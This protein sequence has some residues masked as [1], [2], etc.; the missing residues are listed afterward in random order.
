M[1]TDRKGHIVN[2]TENGPDYIVRMARESNLM[3][4]HG[5]MAW[6]SISMLVTAADLQHAK[7]SGMIRTEI[8]RMN[9]RKALHI[10]AI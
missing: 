8:V 1:N 4:E 6:A 5:R 9:G 3:G 10:I 2:T 7:D